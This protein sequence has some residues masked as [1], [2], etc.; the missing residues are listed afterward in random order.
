MVGVT[1]V[2]PGRA[3]KL[4]LKFSSRSQARDP[5]PDPDAYG[6]MRGELIEDFVCPSVV[7]VVGEL[8]E[9]TGLPR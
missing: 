7:L 1:A 8:E 4:R 5:D 2:D 3:L 9:P 6:K